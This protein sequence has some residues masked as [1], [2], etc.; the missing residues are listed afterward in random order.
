MEE[1]MAF[2]R[3]MLPLACTALSPKGGQEGSC[4][5]WSRCGQSLDIGTGG[6]NPKYI[7]MRLSPGCRLGGRDREPTASLRLEASPPCP[8]YSSTK[9]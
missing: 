2:G 4:L 6:K 9:L 3:S 7:H 8:T 1:V 5:K